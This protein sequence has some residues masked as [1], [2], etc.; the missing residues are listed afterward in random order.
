MRRRL[1]HF[2]FAAAV[3]LCVAV[4]G[5]CQSGVTG[6]AN[7]LVGADGQRFTVQDL[8][9][10]ANDPDLTDDGKR[11]AFRDLGIQDEKLIDALLTL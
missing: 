10:I 4:V 1:C 7:R 9:S 11:Q 5:G 2:G 6:S 3:T 8:Q